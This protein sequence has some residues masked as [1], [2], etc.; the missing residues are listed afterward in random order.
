MVTTVE[1]P[2]AIIISAA[3]AVYRELYTYI[4]IYIYIYMGIMDIYGNLW[5]LWE[6]CGDFLIFESLF[7]G[8]HARRGIPPPPPPETITF[9]FLNPFFAVTISIILV[10]WDDAS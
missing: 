7:P 4:Y 5:E 1:I 9:L 6:Y 10:D 3:R 2:M 8:R